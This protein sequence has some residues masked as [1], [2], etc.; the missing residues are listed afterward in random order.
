MRGL[1][2]NPF[3]TL[4]LL[5]EKPGEW[6]AWKVVP[7]PLALAAVSGLVWVWA[8]GEAAWGWAVALGLLLFAA[9]DWGLLE[10]LPRKG[11]SFGAYQPPLM[12]LTV[13]RGVIA[14]LAAILAIWWP[15]Q[16]VGSLALVQ[17]LVLGVAAYGTLVE[18]FRVQ[19]THLDLPS[20]KLSN[21]GSGLR[22]VQVSDLHVERLTRRERELPA[23]IAG[24]A[25]DLIVLTGDFLSTSYNEDPKALAELRALLEQFH[26]P[27]GVYAVW[28]TI[29]VDM[30][31]LLRPIL[32]ELGITVLEESVARVPAGEA[33]REVATG[34]DGGVWLVGLSCT[35]DL[36]AAGARLRAL[37]A[38][39]PLGAFSLLLYHT[40]DLMPQAAAAGVDLYLAGHTHGGQWRLPGFGAILTSSQYWK[41]Y[42]AGLYCEDG[43]MLYV[44]RGLGMEGFGTPRARFFCPPEVVSI[45]LRGEGE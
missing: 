30:P 34:R 26:A 9:A 8:V 32:D 3:H 16:A 4:L 23:L 11:I 29:E 40:P 27:A 33:S 20:T 7:I 44:S 2:E 14:M 13:L 6:A 18:P 15:W 22:I 17:F 36:D 1:G 39:L 24:L 38:D 42:E 21:P 41:R 25:P 37:L 10:M 31:P 45:T 28:G 5:T 35:R 19:V 12:A 43:T